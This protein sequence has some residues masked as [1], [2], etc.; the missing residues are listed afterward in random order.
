[1]GIACRLQARSTIPTS[2][3]PGSVYIVPYDSVQVHCT[4]SIR[5]LWW[6]LTRIFGGKWNFIIY[7]HLQMPLLPGIE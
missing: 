5:E 6:G 1:M 2:S 7:K 4:E 3:L